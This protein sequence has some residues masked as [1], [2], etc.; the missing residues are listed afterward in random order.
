MKKL[1]KKQNWL[2]QCQRKS[3][4][5]DYA[6][7]NSVIQDISNAVNWSKSRYYE[8][9]ALEGNNPKTTPK[10]Y[11]KILKTSVNGSK[12]PLIP[13][14]LVGNQFVTDFLVKWNLFSYYFSQ[15]CA[16][17][18]KGSSILPN[19]TFETVQKLL[20]LNSVQMN[21]FIVGSKQAP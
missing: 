3:G 10:T 2:F 11:L 7:L 8:C 16:T 18:D 19:I 21:L 12:I 6:S 13:P 15:Q 17:E 1:I 20:R 9:P 4:T 5:L 14:L